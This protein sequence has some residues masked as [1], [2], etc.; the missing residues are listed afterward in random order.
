[1]PRFA[2]NLSMLFTER[3]FIERFAQA[4]AAGF[5]GVEFLFPYDED[6]DA[7]HRELHHHQLELV[8]FN[9]PAGDWAAGERGI[10]N[11][12]NRVDVLRAGAE[13]AFQ[14]ANQL[15]TKR[16]NCL[17][18]LALPEIPSKIQWETVIENLRYAANAAQEAGITQLV[19]PVNTIN[20]PGYLLSSMHQ[21]IELL[22]HVNH[23]NLKL[24]LDVF[25]E[26]RMSGNLTSTIQH[27]IDHIGHIQIA[28]SPDR[29]QPGTGEI[30]Y[31]YVL[32]AIDDAGYDG[33]VSLEYVPT[34]DTLGSLGWLQEY[35][36]WD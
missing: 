14:I 3:P 13:Q 26:Q 10:A 31:P 17:V 5:D 21:G 24:Q 29:H 35:G 34:P 20:V 19:E 28:D 12:P 4:R 1:M 6:I 18:G 27:H 7:I 9:L 33:W 2:A 36:Y 11:D 22:E 25:H 16:V 8:L 15:G 23:P 30:N 32:R